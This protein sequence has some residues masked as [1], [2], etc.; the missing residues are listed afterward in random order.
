MIIYP[1]RALGVSKGFIGKG[2][3][4][5]LLAAAALLAAL[6]GWT[7]SASGRE[8]EAGTGWAEADIQRLPPDLR[9]I[10]RTH[11]SDCPIRAGSSDERLRRLAIDCATNTRDGLAAVVELLEHTDDRGLRRAVAAWFAEAGIHFTWFDPGTDPRIGV[12]APHPENGFELAGRAARA[13][14]AAIK[15]AVTPEEF[16]DFTRHFMKFQARRIAGLYFVKVPEVAAAQGHVAA[17]PLRL[18]FRKLFHAGMLPDFMYNR[19]PALVAQAPRRGPLRVLAFGDF[20]SGTQQQA[21]TAAAMVREDR[22]RPFHMGFTVGDNFYPAGLDD[23]AHPRWHSEWEA[24]YGPMDIT[25]YPTLGNHDYGA[26]GSPL[27]EIIY[28]DDSR[29][30]EMPAPNY[31]VRAG[32]AH[33]FALDT[34]LVLEHQLDWLRRELAASDATWKIVYGHHPIY[35]SARANDREPTDL[36]NRLLPIL[37]QGG[38]AAYFAGHDHAQE[39]YAPQRGVH[40][41]VVGAG[42]AR[43]YDLDQTPA[44]LFRSDQHGFGVLEITDETLTV[45]FINTDG[46]V[47]HSRRIARR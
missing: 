32:N 34:N 6:P 40:L 23:P 36:V 38:V 22:R 1:V 30:W 2:Q 26:E 19:F 8:T 7:G 41:F 25:F 10:A 27:A 47:I 4:A 46:E 42:G 11:L 17:D 29:S 5:G 21:D 45:Q 35:S 16:V 43:T 20:G 3:V 24:L 39:E 18:Q 37:Q 31:A 13:M 12:G 44:S 14:E 33:F 28:S 9:P 15:L